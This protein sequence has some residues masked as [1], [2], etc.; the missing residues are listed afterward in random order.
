M[1]KSAFIGFPHPLSVQ[2][3]PLPLASPLLHPCPVQY[4]P[5]GHPQSRPQKVK[6]YTTPTTTMLPMVAVMAIQSQMASRDMGCCSSGWLWVAMEAAWTLADE[7]K[8]EWSV[9]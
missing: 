3:I 6:A 8:S 2:L 5:S 1:E 4:Q 9:L 7:L